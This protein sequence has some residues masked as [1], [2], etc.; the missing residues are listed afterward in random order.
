MAGTFGPKFDVGR[1]VGDTQEGWASLAAWLRI[2]GRMA[3]GDAARLAR[4]ARRLR[5]LPTLRAAWLDG[6][7]SG[8][9]VAA[10]VANLND[11]TAPLF[12]DQ[13]D[14]LVGRLAPLDTSVAALAMPAGS[15]VTPASTGSSPVA[16]APSSTTGAPAAPSLPPC[17]RLSCGPDTT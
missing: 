8:G 12:R 14:D 6:T 7:V 13:E 5:S 4:T 16:M 11:R 2:R 17:S 10:V 15:P 3:P 1:A 9:H